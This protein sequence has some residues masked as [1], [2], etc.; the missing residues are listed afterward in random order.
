MAIARIDGGWTA[1]WDIANER[2]KFQMFHLDANLLA[3]ENF[4]SRN[5]LFTAAAFGLFKYL[6]G[7]TVSQRCIHDTADFRCRSDRQPVLCSAAAGSLGRY[8]VFVRRKG[9]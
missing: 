7:Y 1:F 3:P 2:N 9:T 4:T 6:P 8:T 5:S